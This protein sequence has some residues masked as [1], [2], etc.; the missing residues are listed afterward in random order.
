MSLEDRDWYRKD[1]EKRRRIIEEQERHKARQIGADAMWNEIERPK[2]QSNQPVEPQVQPSKSLDREKLLHL[3]CPNCEK[4]F[5]FRI[6]AKRIA[7]NICHC[8]NCNRR[9]TIKCETSTDRVLTT[10]LYII[11]IPALLLIAYSLVDSV[12]HLIVG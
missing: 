12:M 6:K 3:T 10:G 11:G 1:Y 4:Q 9:I 2:A 8:P 7:T 5:N